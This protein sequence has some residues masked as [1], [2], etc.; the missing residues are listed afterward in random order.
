MEEKDL[1][2]DVAEKALK[3][4]CRWLHAHKMALQEK[5]AADGLYTCVSLCSPEEKTVFEGEDFPVWDWAGRHFPKK[6]RHPCR[7]PVAVLGGRRRMRL[8]SL[9][10]RRGSFAQCFSGEVQD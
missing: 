10:C 4:T 1:E 3:L 6:R 7:N 8:W 5:V 2:E 9:S